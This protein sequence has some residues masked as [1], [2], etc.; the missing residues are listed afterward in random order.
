MKDYLY[1]SRDTCKQ[2]IYFRS[3]GIYSGECTYHYFTEHV[4]EEDPACINFE[5]H[6]KSMFLNDCDYDDWH[7]NNSCSSYNNQDK[8]DDEKDLIDK[9]GDYIDHKIKRMI[10]YFKTAKLARKGRR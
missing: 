6:Y 5:A 7:Y 4:V 3:V 9:V 1:D 8:E 10:N 2:C